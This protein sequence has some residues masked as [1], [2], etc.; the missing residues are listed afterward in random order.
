MAQETPNDA[1]EEEAKPAKTI[2]EEDRPKLAEGERNDGLFRLGSAMRGIG[3]SGGEIDAALFVTNKERCVKPLK[4]DEVSAIAKSVSGFPPGRRIDATLLTLSLGPYATAVY[5]AIRASCDH[6]NKCF[7]SYEGIADQ[8]KMGRSS[9]IKAVNVLEGAGLI[10]G[11]TRPWNQCKEYTLLDP[12]D[13]VENGDEPESSEA[14]SVNL[15]DDRVSGT[16]AVAA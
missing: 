3:M 9:V 15:S 7:R 2:F 5:L 4:G 6:K 12:R 13:E 14:G 8:T 1:I 10:D 11:E 16:S